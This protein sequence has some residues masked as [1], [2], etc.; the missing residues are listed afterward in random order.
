MALYAMSEC[1]IPKDFSVDMEGCKTYTCIFHRGSRS[2]QGG[3]NIILIKDEYDKYVH[4][5]DF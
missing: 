1:W 2:V 5:I 4:I 3:G